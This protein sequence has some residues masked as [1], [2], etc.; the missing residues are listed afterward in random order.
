MSL[1][2]L[3][4]FHPNYQ[5]EI[6]SEDDIK[7]YEVYAETGGKIGS[8]SDALLD[9]SGRFR[10]LVIDTGLWIFGK[11]VL[12][13]IGRAKMNYDERRVYVSGLTRE[14]VDNLPEY[15]DDMTVDYNYEERVRKV[16]R[17]QTTLTLEEATERDR[18]PY[19]YDREPELYGTK[20]TNER[21]RQTISL[22]E[23]RL[24]ASKERQ[25]T[26]TVSG[27]KRVDSET[28]QVSVPVEKEPIALERTSPSQAREFDPE[29][30]DFQET[31][32]ARIEVYE[33]C[34]DIEKKAFVREEISIK[35][36]VY[37]D[38]I[39]VEEA[40]RREELEMDVEDKPVMHKNR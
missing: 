24:I 31:E 35:K 13:P 29:T 36:A 15:S 39:E 40:V 23:E 4:D 26:G 3:A 10:Y 21:D 2:R 12:L 19:S 16:Y 37:R 20:E 14:Q 5:R 30:P 18:E 7:D 34:V 22:Y 28:S 9:D 38:K 8:V 17:P 32:V 11:H 25:K 6:F 1:V 27:R 33:E